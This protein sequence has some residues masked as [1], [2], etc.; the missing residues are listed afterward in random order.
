MSERD[1]RDGAH[2]EDARLSLRALRAVGPSL[3]RDT[4]ATPFTSILAE[5]LERVPGAY[6]AVL[7]D[8][9]GET[10]DYAGRGDPFEMRV[11][12]AH[13]QLLFQGVARF[14]KIG[15]AR[16]V[17][18]R[19][20]RKSVA[21]TA[22]PDGYALVLVLRPR[23]AFTISS[24]ALAV[25]V[26][27]LSDEAGWMDQERDLGFDVRPW[28]AVTVETDGRGRPA[29]VSA[30]VSVNVE[31]L[32]AVM[33]LPVRERGYRVRTADGTELTLVREAS[34]RWYADEPIR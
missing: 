24:R 4:D 5:L 12:A 31:V 15:E 19:G 26:R 30:N 18:V 25:C 13:G 8:G 34:E 3:P 10:V 32:G 20:G 9:E 17:V 11:A 1:E 22:L 28:F 27:A 21:V 2:D 7:V 14:D 16:W 33:G 29:S 6:A 23:A